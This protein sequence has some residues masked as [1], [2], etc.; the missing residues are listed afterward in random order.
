M[1]RIILVV[2]IMVTCA[3]SNAFC[4]SIDVQSEILGYR[5]L[6][7]LALSHQLRADLEIDPA[8]AL[9]IKE[10]FEK[11]KK[12]YAE[13]TNLFPLNAAESLQERFARIAE[14]K[15]KLQTDFEPK[16]AGELEEIL[17]PKQHLALAWTRLREKFST[18]SSLFNN[19]SFQDYLK[20]ETDT[21]KKILAVIVGQINLERELAQ[22]HLRESADALSKE[23]Q[24][25]IRDI[26]G[27]K[28][29]PLQPGSNY[30]LCID[31]PVHL[32]NFELAVKDLCVS[33]YH[34]EYVNLRPN[35]LREIDAWMKSSRK[36][37]FV[38]SALE[39]IVGPDGLQHLLDKEQYVLLGQLY[40]QPT[41]YQGGL[42]RILQV[43]VYKQY[44]APT[45]EQL[46]A[47]RDLEIGHAKARAE[48]KSVAEKE[49]IEKIVAA[50]TPESRGRLRE[51]L[52]DDLSFRFAV[53]RPD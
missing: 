43:E 23:Q 16:I 14:A 38:T 51:L 47:I 19:K 21:A 6:Q 41:V 2:A 36:R 30:K 42:P 26:V 37:M 35:Q 29:L 50:L 44:I 53:G 34:Q 11:H 28:L 13:L 4:Q 49:T 3:V 52:G 17:T 1:P 7:A 39:E 46:R 9:V 24:D 27:V 25:R 40:A 8:V 5:A 18:V 12:E 32:T 31:T 15:I 22:K 48:I 20:I 45:S 33:A 10:R